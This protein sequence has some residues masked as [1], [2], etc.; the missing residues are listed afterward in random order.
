[1]ALGSLSTPAINHG[2]GSQAISVQD[3]AGRPELSVPKARRPPQPSTA[4]VMTRPGGTGA[5]HSLP[6][7][8]V[9]AVSAGRVV[10][11]VLGGTVTTFRG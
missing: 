3:R 6:A 1:M 10:G 8:Q 7:H 5:A 4:K 11:R 9:A 2:F